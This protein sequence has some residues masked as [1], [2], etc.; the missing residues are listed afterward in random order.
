M[1][2]LPLP[3]LGLLILAAHLAAC[4]SQNPSDNVATTRPFAAK[5]LLR[6]A[7]YEPGSKVDIV[8][9]S[10]VEPIDPRH[11]LTAN[12]QVAKVAALWHAVEVTLNLP[13]AG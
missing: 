1:Q 5:P 4:A 6:L 9:Q 10:E 3:R 7:S 12:D 11:G 8:T 13:T 2:R